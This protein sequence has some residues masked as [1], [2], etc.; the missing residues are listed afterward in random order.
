[1]DLSSRGGVG[2][3]QHLSSLD[4]CSPNSNNLL[5]LLTRCSRPGLWILYWK[6]R[7]K[8]GPKKD[9]TPWKGLRKDMN[10][11]KRHEKRITMGTN[12]RMG[13]IRGS[14]AGVEIVRKRQTCLSFHVLCQLKARL[15]WTGKRWLQG[16]LQGVCSLFHAPSWAHLAHSPH[17]NACKDRGSESASS[18]LR[19]SYP[20]LRL[21]EG[22]P[23]LFKAFW[24]ESYPFYGLLKGILSFLRLFEGNPILFY[25]LLKGIL[26]FLLR[27][28]KGIVTLS[29]LVLCAFFSMMAF[30]SEGRCFKGPFL[31][32]Y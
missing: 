27:L 31:G 6:S 32:A 2:F 13:S 5:G 18:K 3:L 30:S 28:F 25:G 14:D 26:S 10:P 15:L 19:D 23:T 8:K 11:P 21:F 20:F 9:R 29:A 12:I 17:W 4:E 22:N 16:E 7:P 24:R 1:M